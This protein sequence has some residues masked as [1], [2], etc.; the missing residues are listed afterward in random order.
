MR[1][2]V[3]VALVTGTTALCAVALIGPEALTLHQQDALPQMLG[4]LRDALSGMLG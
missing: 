3:A 1:W 4:R 2:L